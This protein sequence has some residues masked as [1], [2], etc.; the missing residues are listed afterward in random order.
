MPLGIRE[1]LPIEYGRKT[2]A[3]LA[4]ATWILGI[5][6]ALSLSGPTT[7]TKFEIEPLESLSYGNMTITS[8]S[9]SE[10]WYD[11]YELFIYGRFIIKDTANEYTY[12]SIDGKSYH[13]NSS[14]FY[15]DS[16]DLTYGS[17]FVMVGNETF[18]QSTFRVFVTNGGLITVKMT[19]LAVLLLT[20]SI[21]C[22][23][24]SVSIYFLVVSP[25]RKESERKAYEKEK[26]DLQSQ[27]KPDRLEFLVEQTNR[28]IEQLWKKIE[29]L[30]KRQA[31]LLT[32]VGIAL[33]GMIAILLGIDANLLTMDL[34]IIIYLG[35]IVSILLL[36]VPVYILLSG[37]VYEEEIP[38]PW[39]YEGNIT[40][41]RSRIDTLQ[42]DIERN[43]GMI[44]SWSQIDVFRANVVEMVKL[45][46]T[47]KT[48][49][50]EYQK[51]LKYFTYS[52]LIAIG[53]ILLVIGIQL[54][55]IFILSITYLL[56]NSVL[57]TVLVLT[58][59]VVWFYSDYYT[60]ILTL[61][62]DRDELDTDLAENTGI[63]LV[64]SKANEY[65]ILV[66]STSGY[67]EDQ[68]TELQNRVRGSI[69]KPGR[70]PK[71][72]PNPYG[73]EKDSFERCGKAVPILLVS[74]AGSKTKTKVYPL[75][76]NDG[77]IT[78][79]HDF[80]ESLH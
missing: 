72:R 23:A 33:A 1:S 46:F 42:V 52:I 22:G 80:L 66:K 50:D 5:G 68:F 38:S 45:Y 37:F 76:N 41:T 78:T 61:Y 64:L 77:S 71:N 2:I 28:V 47:M 48:R 53:G 31:T 13:S 62:V 26:A 54:N 6:F 9:N 8:Y 16:R 39:S 15:V 12:L 7:V 32:V 59:P 65:G 25:M 36:L 35:F 55:V 58:Y 74:S 40:E 70:L 51:A 27:P 73:S 43:Y 11:E 20:I 18:M 57:L 34:L 21:Y 44:S 24:G 3:V 79:I 63:T 69:R 56:I 17:H 19:A 75:G 67:T 49:E 60:E 14:T 29:F 10:M 4:I 30:Q